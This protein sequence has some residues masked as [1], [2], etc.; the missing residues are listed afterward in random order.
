[1]KLEL[2]GGSA[3]H[4]RNQFMLCAERDLLGPLEEYG[5]GAG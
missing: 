2:T 4:V 5:F 1:M 3:R